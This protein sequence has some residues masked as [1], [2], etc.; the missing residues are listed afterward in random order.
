M[1]DLQS[2][3]KQIDS[4]DSEIIKLFEK[5]MKV[6][7]KVAQYKKENHIPILNVSREEEVI[8][9]NV[10]RL[11]NKEF[12]SAAEVVFKTIMEV[13]KEEQAKLIA[14]SSSQEK[15]HY[16]FVEDKKTDNVK[17]GYYG[18]PGSFSNEAEV[19]YFGEN[20]N[21]CSYT[22]FEDVFAALKN[23]EIKYGVVPVENSST[24][25]ITEVHD[26]LRKYGLFIVGEKIIKI[27]Q[28]LLGVK[29][30]SIED[31]KQV[32]SHP[33]GFKQSAV[34]F[35]EHPDMKLITYYSTSKSA[36]LVAQKNSKAFA[37]VSGDMAAKLY[38]LHIIQQN[39]NFSSNNYTKFIIIGKELEINKK[40]NKISIL[41]SIPHKAG[42]LYNV[43]KYFSQNNL[44]MMRIESRPIAEKP[45]EYFFYIDF[46]GNISEGN[47]AKAL[48]IIKENSNYFKILGNYEADLSTN[49]TTEQAE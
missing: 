28:H 2:L 48:N 35:K 22:N 26:L 41:I 43:L 11:N 12:A 34:F 16:K 9:K 15:P 37:A 18:E 31:I 45:W 17:I 29:G 10:G 33:Q 46:E 8:K 13:S 42:S 39:I 14:D 4:I 23:D 30:A 38:N 36:K 25:G 7:V 47:I 27:N 19:R 40:S 1:E 5:R 3:R 6:S 32:Y 44:N 20:I 49:E 21:A 24:G